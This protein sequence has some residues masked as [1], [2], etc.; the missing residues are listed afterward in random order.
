MR[1]AKCEARNEILRCA[2]NDEREKD[3]RY[4]CTVILE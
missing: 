1:N 4:V 3:V 2:Q